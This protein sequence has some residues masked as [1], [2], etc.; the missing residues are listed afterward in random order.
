MV[1]SMSRISTAP[2]RTSAPDA[3]PAARSTVSLRCRNPT[4]PST[5]SAAAFATTSAPYRVVNSSDG[6]TRTSALTTPVIASTS[7]HTS[8]VRE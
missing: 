5:T 7:Q 4:P 2:R 8:A 6:A 1:A 3:P